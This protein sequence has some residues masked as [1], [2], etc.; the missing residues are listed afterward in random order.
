MF[1]TLKEKL[2][3]RNLG[4]RD[5]CSAQWTVRAESLKSVR[6]NWSAINILSDSS[7]EDK[8]DSAMIHIFYFLFI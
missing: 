7:L 6:D 2:P 1:S 3:M 5:L 8:L 4:F